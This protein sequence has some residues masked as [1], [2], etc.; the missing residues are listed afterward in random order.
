VKVETTRR[1]ASGADDLQSPAP[2]GYLH[3]AYAGSLEEFGTPRRLPRCGGWI[4]ERS[5]AGTSLRDAMGCYPMFACEDW[6]SIGDD[7]VELGHD[8]V[9]VCLVTDPFGD[10]TEAGLRDCF[11]DRVRPFKQHFV[12]D[13]SRS[14]STFV[15]A[16]H[17]RNARRALDAVAVETVVSP[18]S[19]LE[20]WCELYDALVRRRNIRGLRA[21]SRSAFARQLEV[22]GLEI[23]RATRNGRTEAMALW[24]VAGPVAYYHLGASSDRGYS[25]RASFALFDH[26]IRSF[27]GR[28]L[29]WLDLGGGPG[30][31]RP[32]DEGLV[33]FKRGWST[34][35]RPAW[36]CARV[37]DPRRY[38]YLVEARST[39]PT[40]YFPAYREGE[41]D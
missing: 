11:G 39:P 38:E 7:L 1:V 13:L 14:P 15:S 8:L 36:F 6:S 35:T 23:Q 22:P 33:R 29:S 16:H 30:A 17:R 34:G 32:R 25:L 26:A 37:L 2:A 27:A 3:S 31:G 41:F 21:F 4:L 20:E 18:S 12:V 28:G 40:E 10:Y 5:I 9:S 24:C 19:C